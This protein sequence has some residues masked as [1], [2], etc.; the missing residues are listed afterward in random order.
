MDANARLPKTCVRDHPSGFGREQ[1][2]VLFWQ[3]F[4]E[5]RA[6][7]LGGPVRLRRVVQVQPSGGRFPS[8][9]DPQPPAPLVELPEPSGL[10]F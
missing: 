7:L 10:V 2:E 9:G 1:S 5:H 3:L 8:E 4:P 6:R